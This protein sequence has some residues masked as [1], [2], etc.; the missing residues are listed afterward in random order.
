MSEKQN[1]SI[2]QAREVVEALL[3]GGVEWFAYCPGSRNAP[4]AYVLSAYER[5]GLISVYS[6]AQ[7][8][9]A[10][11][12]ALGV[13][14]ALGGTR[15]VAVFTTSGSAVAQ[16]HAALEEARHQSLP[17]IAVT[18]DRP[19]ELVGV[20]ASQTTRQAG[21]FGPT[22]VADLDVPAGAT[23]G[24]AQRVTRVLRRATG[25][26]G[27]S[28]PAHINVAFRDP[29]VPSR[30]VVLPV[31][32]AKAQHE[33]PSGP[34]GF[35]VA[36]LWSKVIDPTL[37]T[38]VIA[39]DCEPAELPVA[40]AIGARAA[41]LGIPILAEP[42]S[43]LTSQKT[44]VPHGPL[45]APQVKEGL[46]QLIVLG[47]PTLS[48]PVAELLAKEG[49]DKVVVSS[50]EEW[51]DTVGNAAEVVHDLE[52]DAAPNHSLTWLDTCREAGVGASEALSQAEGTLD[53]L[54][55]ARAI[56]EANPEV[57][58]WL[59]ASNTVR[60]FDFAANKP[61]R[62]D[63]FSNR[64]LAGID[65]TI[66]AALGAQTAT[67]KPFRAVMGD[68]TFI[69][70][71]PALGSVQARQPQGTPKPNL[72]IIVLDDGGGTIFES[73]E[74]GRVADP[75]TLERYFAVPQNVDVCAVAGALGWE[76]TCIHSLSELSAALGKPME[77][78]S[79]LHVSLPSPAGL[80][81]AVKR[82]AV[83][84]GKLRKP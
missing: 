32:S 37:N 19:F 35:G 49:A 55:V 42:S 6:F 73:L 84:W 45:V 30:P 10:A 78:L 66:A 8:S 14:K 54:S 39:G 62:E 5:A 72:Q 76:V 71:L 28:G 53:H 83:A 4:L 79:V 48:R 44:W 81:E 13:A 22:V 26:R 24:V 3:A 58:L 41:A 23:R 52:L 1:P 33:V 17:V 38:L 51:P 46:E 59:G 67:D 56:W 61:G 11:F 70:D 82:G 80:F 64:G 60:A 7:E 2:T 9:T 16:M 75:E 40:R 31:A 25:Y 18:A 63:V 21:I 27:R 65:G 34:L 12:W 77:G 50:H 68:L 47:K 29:L 20:G 36:P 74:H 69:Y 15:P 57:S 43:N